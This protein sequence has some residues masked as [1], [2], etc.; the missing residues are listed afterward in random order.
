MADISTQTAL[1]WAGC[2]FGL[3]GAW[4]L[5]LNNQH[6]GYG[7]VAFLVSNM[8]WIGFGLLTNVPGLVVMQMGFTA[9]SLLGIKNW[10]VDRMRP[11]SAKGW[12][13]ALKVI[14][15]GAVGRIPSSPP[16]CRQKRKLLW[17]I[18]RATRLYANG[19]FGPRTLHAAAASAATM[20]S[21]AV[22]LIAL[23]AEVYPASLLAG[24]LVA[25]GVVM[26]RGTA[27]RTWADQLSRLVAQYGLL[28]RAAEL[29][30][31]QQLRTAGD[32]EPWIVLEWVDAERQVIGRME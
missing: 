13:G 30:L 32:L 8:L 25:F 15:G 28:D 9:T 20:A 4:L 17:Q 5:A 2:A 19:A 6:S 16:D 3:L 26:V 10:L 29:R 7:F 1:E 22:L 12:E 14:K 27:S 23:A 21:I 18:E 11:V 24:G 31:R